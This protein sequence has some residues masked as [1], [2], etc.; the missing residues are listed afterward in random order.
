MNNEEIKKLLRDLA[1]KADAEGNSGK[2]KIR[3]DKPEE[4]KET[5]KE[6]TAPVKEKKPASRAVEP[7]EKEADKPAQRE[8]KP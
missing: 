4:K 7:E 2:V 3:F 6:R 1:A 5:P 8:E